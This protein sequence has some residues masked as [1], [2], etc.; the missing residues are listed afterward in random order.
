MKNL[1][2]VIFVLFQTISYSQSIK[3]DS[4]LNILD[5]FINPDTLYNPADLKVYFSDSDTIQYYTEVDSNINIDFNDTLVT[6]KFSIVEYGEQEISNQNDFIRFYNKEKLL[7]ISSEKSLIN[8]NIFMSFEREERYG[9]S[10]KKY[11]EGENG[12]RIVLSYF[13]FEDK[14]TLNWIS[15]TD[16][17][18][19][20]HKK[21]FIK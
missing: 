1:I 14:K 18:S 7:V 3:S 19:N 15:I 9:V 4:V 2:L 6:N 12:E 17:T 13:V 21:Y 8:Q 16:Y 11:F 10:L 5:L 20:I